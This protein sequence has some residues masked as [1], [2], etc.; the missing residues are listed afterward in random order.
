MKSFIDKR[1]FVSKVKNIG[2]G[3]FTSEYIPTETTIEVAISKH[4][5]GNQICEDLKL[6]NNYTYHYDNVKNSLAL[7]FGSIYNHASAG[8]NNVSYSIF[9]NNIIYKT[10]KP[11]EK[12]Q[13][14]T[15]D[16][17]DEWFKNK[18]LKIRNKIIYANK[19]KK[20]S[21]FIN[22]KI[23][24]KKN[25]IYTNK[26]IAKNEIIEIS[27]TINFKNVF[28]LNEKHSLSKLFFYNKKNNF[29]IPLGFANIYK[30]NKN[31]NVNYFLKNKK[32][33][34]HANVKIKSGDELT[35]SKQNILSFK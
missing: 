31:H 35:I 1:L 12:N 28:Y 22:K 34:F 16:Y 20:T 32:V 27:H 18:N 23:E 10:V 15:I 26:E 17:S 2:Y 19:T 13:Q 33:Y 30:V 29:L 9:K 6:I 21:I 24:I 3:I 25:S 11:V 7:G 5:Y 14:L 8:I 4:V